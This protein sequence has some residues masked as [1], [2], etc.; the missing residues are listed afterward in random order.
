MPQW[1]TSKESAQFPKC[2]NFIIFY[3][4][5]KIKNKKCSI[6]N[7]SPNSINDQIV[8]FGKK[9]RKVNPNCKG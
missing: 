1:I 3:S 4:T 6:Q 2:D 8:A 7:A 9:I 5:K